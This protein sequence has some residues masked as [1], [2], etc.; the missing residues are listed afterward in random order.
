MGKFFMAS[1]KRRHWW[2]HGFDTTTKPGRIALS[3]AS[4]QLRKLESTQ[5]HKIFTR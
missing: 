2:I 1:E 4:Q 5:Q 3:V